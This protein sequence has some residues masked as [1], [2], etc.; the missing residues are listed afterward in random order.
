MGR[1]GEEALAKRE[2]VSGMRLQLLAPAVF[3]LKVAGLAVV[4]SAAA[5]LGVGGVKGGGGG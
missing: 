3:F 5:F 4:V 2:E 1:A